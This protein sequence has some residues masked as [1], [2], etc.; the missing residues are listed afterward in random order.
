MS[1]Y[2][3]SSEN[4]LLDYPLE[5]VTTDHHSCGLALRTG[6]SRAF[7]IIYYVIILHAHSVS[8]IAELT[9]PVSEL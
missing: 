7:H 2:S 1:S 8:R 6:E 9:F 3:A 4:E 5:Q